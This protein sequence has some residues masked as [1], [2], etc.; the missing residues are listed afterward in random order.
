MPFI[1][2]KSSCI[3]SSVA[4]LGFCCSYFNVLYMSMLNASSGSASASFSYWSWH[5]LNEA[6]NLKAPKGKSLWLQCSLMANSAIIYLI[7]AVSSQTLHLRF[8][9]NYTGKRNLRKPVFLSSDMTNMTC[10]EMLT[11]VFNMPSMHFLLMEMFRVSKQPFKADLIFS[12]MNCMIW[13][14]YM[15]IKWLDLEKL[16]HR[17]T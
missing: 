6:V 17:L 12:W 11:C 10:K 7:F 1:A 9:C 4:C 3:T 13:L 14:C 8:C 15:T 16:L 2:Q 5:F